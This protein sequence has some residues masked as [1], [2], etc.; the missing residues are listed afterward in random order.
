MPW[1]NGFIERWFR[2]LKTSLT[3]KAIWLDEHAQR[4]ALIAFAHDHYWNERPHQERDNAPPAGT[5]STIDTT[6]DIVRH[7]RCGGLI[8]VYRRAAA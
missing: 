8:N 1:R 5:A 3:R 4:E 6:A 7:E 2:T